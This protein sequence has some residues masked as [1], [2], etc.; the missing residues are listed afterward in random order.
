MSRT[1]ALLVALA[2]AP[3]VFAQRPTPGTTARFGALRPEN[4]D[5]YRKLFVQPPPVAQRSAQ[6]AAK[7]KVVCGLTIIE[8]DTSIDSKF[9]VT[10]KSDT[11][12]YTLRK[13]EPPVC[14][15]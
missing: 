6:A 10:K 11:V 14:K 13:I 7:R 8:G 1:A 9:F 15:P 5:P 4:P 12:D 3:P 2:I